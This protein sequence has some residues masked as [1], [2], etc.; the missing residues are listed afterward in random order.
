[1][2]PSLRPLSESTWAWI[3]DREGYGWSNCGLVVSDDQAL[4][5]DTQFTLAATR[6]LLAAITSTA[7]GATIST[8][9]N[10][11][12]NGD[13]TW[14]NQ[15]LPD[16]EIITSTASAAHL[17]HEMNPTQL[18]ELCRADPSTPVVAYA[19]EHFGAF[20]FS[21]IQVRAAD[22]T[23]IGREEVKVGTT[24]VELIDLGAGHSEGDVAV[25][26]PEEGV[27]FAGDAVFSGMH[28]VVWSGS[29]SE[30]V[31]SCQAILDTGATV[32][33]PG[34]G[35]V[36]G[37]AG[38]REFLDHLVDVADTAAACATA[39]I[40]LEE[41]ARRVKAKHAGDWAHPERLFTSTAAAYQDAGVEGVPQG[42]FALVEGMAALAA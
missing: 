11:H 1:M 40:P 7:P 21:G 25:H 31:A 6:E 38:V 12:Q 33:V 37:R 2:P 39:G 27:L 17:C 15:L 42:T 22:R 36:L 8:V 14:G 9:V 35:P 3:P 32:I 19:A 28:T 41:A 18:T 24:L 23:F 20:D 16:A 34:H 5:V 10:S 30:A 13:H 26:V 4:L 29:L